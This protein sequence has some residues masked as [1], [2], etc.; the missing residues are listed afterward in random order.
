MPLYFFRIRNGKFSGASEQGTEC[1]DRNAA[2]KALTSACADMAAGISRKLEQNAEWQMEL[3][4]E[5]KQPV[6]RIRIVAESLDC[7]ERGR[8]AAST[9]FRPQRGP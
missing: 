9:N 7:G 2:W 5:S 1:A 6:F 3:L 8:R 4:D